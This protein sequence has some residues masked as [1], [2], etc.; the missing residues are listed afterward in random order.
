L[1]LWRPWKTKQTHAYSAA[2]TIVVGG[3]PATA[4]RHAVRRRDAKRQRR[5]AKV[6]AAPRATAVVPTVAA[7]TDVAV[8]CFG[9]TAIMAVDATAGAETAVVADA[10][11]AVAAK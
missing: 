3:H 7:T 10:M 11:V 5:L 1:S 9:A 4:L 8:G 6:I 2:G